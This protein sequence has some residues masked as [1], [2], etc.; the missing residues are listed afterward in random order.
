[1]VLKV[2][3]KFLKTPVYFPYNSNICD[4]F[5]HY[6]TFLQIL[7]CLMRLYRLLNANAY[8]VINIGF[9]DKLIF[10]LWDLSIVINIRL[11]AP[12]C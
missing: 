3:I 10:L 5:K 4:I 8:I 6:V 11:L 9:F 12:G 7:H 1:M 2:R